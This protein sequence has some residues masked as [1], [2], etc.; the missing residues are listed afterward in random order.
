MM[1]KRYK[2]LLAALLVC[3]MGAGMLPAEVSAAGGQSIGSGEYSLIV[4]N[5][6][7]GAVRYEVAIGNEEYEIEV[8][9]YDSYEFTGIVAGTEY[10]VTWIEGTEAKF[11]YTEPENKTAS[12]GREG[13]VS[14]VISS[15]AQAAEISTASTVRYR[16]YFISD[17]MF[18]FSLPYFSTSLSC[19]SC[20]ADRL[21]V[22]PVPELSSYSGHLH[23][24]SR[25]SSA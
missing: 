25:M 12:S 21:L 24:L 18:L 9:G 17:I 13:L 19:R 15:F 11:D 8:P 23:R 2:K 22:L 3:C 16:L 10:T 20:R 5:D 6:C 14:S 7:A 4:D 1:T